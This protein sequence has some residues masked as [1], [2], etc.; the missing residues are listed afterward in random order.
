MPRLEPVPLGRA[1]DRWGNTQPD[2]VT[3]GLGFNARNR[4]G[5]GSCFG[6]DGQGGHLWKGN[7]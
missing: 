2:D 4:Q 1:G 5:K 6:S 3:D 7:V